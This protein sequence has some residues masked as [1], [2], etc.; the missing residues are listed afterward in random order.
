MQALFV[1]LLIAQGA[2]P[3]S[4]TTDLDRIRKELERRPTITTE[5]AADESGRPV[6]KMH[7][8]ARRPQKQPWDNW[9][10]NVPSYI[11]PW[12]RGDHAEFLERVTPE[13]FRSATL[14]PIGIPVIPLMEALNKYF[15]AARRKAQEKGARDEVSQALADVLACRADPTRPGC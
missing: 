5:A 7:I 1:C 15:R 3:V 9:S 2:P 4:D 14:Y 10:N 11:R 6:F 8:D 12:W 13:E